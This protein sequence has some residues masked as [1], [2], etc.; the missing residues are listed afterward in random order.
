MSGS[1]MPGGI[2]DIDIDGDYVKMTGPVES[3]SEGN[4]TNE[5]ISKLMIRDR[6]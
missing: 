4:F 1:S 2:I 3:V 5:F 6:R